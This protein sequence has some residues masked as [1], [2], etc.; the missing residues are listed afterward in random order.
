MSRFPRDA[1]VTLLPARACRRR[2]DGRD[3]GAGANPVLDE[4]LS[5]SNA[6]AAS[7]EVN[8]ID[9]TVPGLSGGGRALF[10]GRPGL[11][12]PGGGVEY[13]FEAIGLKQTAEQAWAMLRKG[14]TAT[15][16]GMIPLDEKVELPGLDFLSEKKI[17]GSTMGSNRFRQDM[18]RYVDMYLD[19]RL[20]LDEL[21][22]ARIALDEVN[23]GFA[24]TAA[25][26]KRRSASG[27]SSP[28]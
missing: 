25:C 5:T 19:G 11:A 20:K 15:V 4:R 7:T 22:S 21:V 16:I 3:R 1:C 14:G 8:A 9:L 23:D 6:D 13:S 10:P 17:Q 27:G 12:G 26:A 2:A 28:A 24:A 18:P